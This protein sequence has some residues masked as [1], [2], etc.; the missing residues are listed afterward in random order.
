MRSPAGRCTSSGAP[1]SAAT[2][3]RNCCG[4]RA[5]SHQPRSARRQGHY[6]RSWRL[7][8][9]AESLI[10][11]SAEPTG[12]IGTSPTAIKARPVVSL[13]TLSEPT[14]RRRSEDENDPTPRPGDGAEVRNREREWSAAGPSRPG[15][16][17]DESAGSAARPSPPSSVPF[18]EESPSLPP[19][20]HPGP[21]SP[22]RRSSRAFALLQPRRWVQ[23]WPEPP[24]SKPGND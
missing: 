20:V 3:E 11:E 18:D 19:A 21:V 22:R 12:P 15:C 14:R 7:A 10:P 16:P 4:R 24:S 8:G 6:R 1:C 2:S 9:R 13:T 5:S 17:A 23:G